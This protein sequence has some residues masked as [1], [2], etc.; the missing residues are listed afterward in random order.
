MT[1]KLGEFL[2]RKGLLTQVQIDK[3]LKTQLI[4]GGH[5]GTCL[6]E[7]AL[8][9]E[10]ALGKSLSEMLGVR[11]APPEML[12]NLAPHVVGAV[13][14]KAVEKH[15]F[16]PIK[17]ENKVMNIATMDPTDLAKMDE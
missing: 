14:V 17:F 13:S 5:L 6:I 9:D 8:I 3:A 12:L 15:L 11:Y 1:N 10:E 2:I 7:L 4:F 16:I